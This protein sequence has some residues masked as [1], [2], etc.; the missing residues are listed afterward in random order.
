MLALVHLAEPALVLDLDGIAQILEMAEDAR[1]VTGLAEDVEVLGRPR[2]PGVGADRIGAGQQEGQVG[3]AQLLQRLGVEG[4][5]LGVGQCRRGGGD[6][7][8]DGPV[9]GLRR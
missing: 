1:A 3:P 6:D 2:D 9:L 8:F 4:L 7:R 5:G